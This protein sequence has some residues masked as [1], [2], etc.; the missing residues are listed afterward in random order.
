[1]TMMLNEREVAARLGI[2][3]KTLQA[4]RLARKGP[5]YSKLG[6]AV[7]Y[8]SEAVDRFVASTQ[9]RVG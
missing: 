8:S 3:V 2:S 1:M 5:T 6:R 7:R 9:V 4:W